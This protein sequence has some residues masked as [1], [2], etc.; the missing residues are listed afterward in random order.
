ATDL[1][2]VA[3]GEIVAGEYPTRDAGGS[4]RLFSTVRAPYRDARGEVIG[5][6]GVAR[7]VTAEREHERT[8][9]R[10][11]DELARSNTLLAAVVEGT[12]DVVYVKDLDERYLLM[13]QAGA[14]LLGVPAER[15]AGQ[16]ID[17]FLPER[18]AEPIRARDREVIDSGATQTGEDAVSIHGVERTFLSVVAPW[19]DAS[20]AIVG[21]VGISRDIT[22]MKRARNAI[23]ASEKRYRDLFEM[24]KGLICV[25]DLE[26][27]LITVN[28]ASASIL[29]YAPE[30]LAGR[31]LQEFVPAEHRDAFARYLAAL[32]AD[33]EQSGL[34]VLTARGG[35]HRWL[36]FT[37]HVY[38]EPGSAP[39]VI[40][41]AQDITERRRYEQRLR[42]ISL[43]DPLT[44]LYNR[45]YLETREQG[46][47]AGARFGTIVVDLD[48]FKQI[49]DT[50]G[51][52][53]G[54]EVL[55]AMGR[56]LQMHARRDDAVIRMG[57][58]EFLVLLDDV[59]ERSLSAMVERI[60]ADGARAPC[61]FSIGHALRDGSEPLEQ[62]I[63]RADLALYRVRVETRGYERRKH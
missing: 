30:E 38:R 21:L 49:N 52:Q 37:N 9:R 16:R 25:H 24:S 7:D 15:I 10:Q 26:G 12:S 14:R 58:D 4:E 61:G 36:Q 3:S 23:A 47:D 17:A 43:T 54:D 11:A 45:R 44:G 56:F 20:G 28:P 5:V 50:L 55:V 39:Y 57:G 27:H 53:R 2:V 63:D 62:T 8:I 42:E 48:H 33:D 41:H 22:E 60:V 19:R 1:A 35:E 13:N 59:D 29:G 31:M 34:L 32:D 18:V 6:V 46:A 40:G 51:H